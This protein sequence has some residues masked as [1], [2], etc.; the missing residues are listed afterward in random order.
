MRRFPV[1][2][3]PFAPYAIATSIFIHH[4]FVSSPIS[5]SHHPIPPNQSEFAV[6]PEHV[7]TTDLVIVS[8]PSSVRPRCVHAP[9]CTLVLC[10]RSHS[11]P[12]RF[13][14]PLLCFYYYL[15][16]SCPLRVTKTPR[17][18]IGLFFLVWLAVL[19]HVMTHTQLSLPAP[20]PPLY[21]AWKLPHYVLL[22]VECGWAYE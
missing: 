14:P 16:I 10:L 5:R 6:Y 1:D 13:I 4:L 11:H 8:S 17:L 22:Y 7:F 3:S 20:P 18:P 2:L 12:L 9:P 15:P 21:K 19:P